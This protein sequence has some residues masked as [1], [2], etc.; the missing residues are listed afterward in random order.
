MPSQ[1]LATGTT[2]SNRATIVFDGN[3]AM[4]TP[5]WVNTID[6]TE[7]TSRV[8]AL[9][10]TEPLVGFTVNWSGTDIGSGIQ[11]FTVYASDNGGP[12]APWQR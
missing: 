12:F 6:N 1:T 8:G 2:V 4:N 7:P 10:A 3:T 9:P 5:N 11:D